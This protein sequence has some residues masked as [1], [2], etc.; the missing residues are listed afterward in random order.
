MDSKAA[1]ER[2]VARIKKQ[3]DDVDKELKQLAQGIA[4]AEE[5][6]IKGGSESD[7]KYW[8]EKGLLLVKEKGDFQKEKGRL[9]K[10]EQELREWMLGITPTACRAYRLRCAKCSQSQRNQDE[11]GCSGVYHPF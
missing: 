10:K 11:G 3:I 8:Q 4:A 7:R 5:E 2:E 9:L 1:T 6:W